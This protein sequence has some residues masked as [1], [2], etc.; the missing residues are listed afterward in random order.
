MPAEEGRRPLTLRVP[1]SEW[2]APYGNSL[3]VR[4]PYDAR[5]LPAQRTRA[6]S[7]WHKTQNSD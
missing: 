7:P 3:S 2:V 6:A 1:L 5:W 4:G